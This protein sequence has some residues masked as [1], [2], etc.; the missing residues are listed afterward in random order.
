[1]TLS[2]PGFARDALAKPI[3]DLTDDHLYAYGTMLRHA[4]ERVLSLFGR[5]LLSG[6]THTCI[7]QEIC[8]MAVVRALDRPDDAVMSNHRNHGHFLTYSGDFVGLL[9]EVMGREAGVCR[10]YGGSQHI[11]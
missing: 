3:I 10:G 5:G 1:M 2:L 7:G 6:T 4:E 11:A 8:Q 9:A